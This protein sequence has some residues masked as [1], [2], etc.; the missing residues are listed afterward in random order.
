MREMC[1][2][3]ALTKLD[4]AS[5]ER[6]AVGKLLLVDDAARS[7]RESGHVMLT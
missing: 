6:A 4:E 7:E 2:A 1:W 5:F 3:H